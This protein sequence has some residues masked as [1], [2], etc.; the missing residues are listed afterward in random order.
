AICGSFVQFVSFVAQL[1]G[2]GGGGP[3]AGLVLSAGRGMNS[4]LSVGGKMIRPSFQ[5][6]FACSILTFLEETK[7]HQI[8]RSPTGSPPSIM[9]VVLSV[10]RMIGSVPY[11]KASL[12][13]DW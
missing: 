7:F 2:S 1:N 10:A 3:P 5:S 8:N 4:L 6:A 12:C 13:P 9:S 11:V